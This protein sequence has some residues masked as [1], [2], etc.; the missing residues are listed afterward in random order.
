[1]M[2]KHGWQTEINED[3]LNFTTPVIFAR[4]PLQEAGR[5]RS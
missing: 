1:M 4:T 5:R 2:K 3:R